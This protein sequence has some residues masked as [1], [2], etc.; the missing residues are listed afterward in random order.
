MRKEPLSQP[1][2]MSVFVAPFLQVPPSFRIADVYRIPYILMII[3]LIYRGEPH[4]LVSYLAMHCPRSLTPILRCRALMQVSECVAAMESNTWRVMFFFVK[5][6][7]LKL[8][9]PSITP[10]PDKV[11]QNHVI[12]RRLFIRSSHRR[13]PAP[14]NANFGT[15]IRG[16]H[17]HL[18]GPSSIL[19]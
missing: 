17:A 5:M 6:C 10:Y 15:S 12:N 2:L 3:S 18:P 7:R 13:V 4:Y 1:A 16:L 8:D 19:Q 9:H 11:C 14:A